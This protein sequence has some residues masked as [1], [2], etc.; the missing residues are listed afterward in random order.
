[1]ER[2]N[3]TLYDNGHDGLVTIVANHWAEFQALLNQFKG[4][5]M[6]IT[7]VVSVCGVSGLL[8]IVSLC[9]NIYDHLQRLGIH[10]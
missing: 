6:A 10:P 7:I 8:G 9:I 2:V 5:R 4:A 3:S 1:M